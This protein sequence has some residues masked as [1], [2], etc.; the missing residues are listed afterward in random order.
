MR[1]KTLRR[2][3]FYPLF[4]FFIAGCCRNNPPGPPDRVTIEPASD[5]TYTITMSRGDTTGGQG[6]YRISATMVLTPPADT[7]MNPCLMQT[8]V[9]MQKDT[10]GGQ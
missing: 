3:L 6:S 8:V 7:S 4:I 1:I 9:F 10:T 5:S 2:I